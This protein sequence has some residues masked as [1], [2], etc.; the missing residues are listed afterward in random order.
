MIPASVTLCILIHA[1]KQLKRLK[2]RI[3]AVFMKADRKGI[4]FKSIYNDE[5]FK[6]C[7]EW[8]GISRI[9]LTKQFIR[10]NSKEII[11]ERDMLLIFYPQKDNEVT[12]RITITSSRA[13]EG[14][15]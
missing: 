7:H 13:P 4:S 2:G 10:E 5:P 8:K 14:Y 12:E 6:K 15:N 3:G 1:L 9:I 11:C